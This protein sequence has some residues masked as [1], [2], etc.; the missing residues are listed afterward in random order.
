MA[1]FGTYLT[2]KSGLAAN[3]F[4]PTETDNSLQQNVAQST[5]QGLT[6]PNLDPLKVAFSPVTRAASDI[7]GWLQK[8]ANVWQQ[9]ISQVGTWAKQSAENQQSAAPV[10]GTTSGVAVDT[11]GRGVPGTQARPF[12]TQVEQDIQDRL[13]G[14]VTPSMQ[15]YMGEMYRQGAEQRRAAK[16]RVGAQGFG[17]NSGLV[18]EYQNAV[19]REVAKGIQQYLAQQQASAQQQAMD[20][21]KQQQAFGLGQQTL[22]QADTQGMRDYL[23]KQ[24]QLAEDKRYHDLLAQQQQRTLTAQ[25][26]Q[27]MMEYNLKKQQEEDKQSSSLWNLFGNVLGGVAG[28]NPA[29]S[30]IGKILGF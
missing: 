1:T 25:E 10:K 24:A 27:W 12:T 26:Q 11:F 4:A 13:A 17:G 23:V 9:P 3:Q 5:N 19:D 16:D 21:D 28:A 6:L 20:W 18:L 14:Q 8:Q 22:A 15:A 2:K 29:T 30:I 7:G